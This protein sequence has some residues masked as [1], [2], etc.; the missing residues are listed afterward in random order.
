MRLTRWLLTG[1]L[2]VILSCSWTAWAIAASS[3]AIRAYDDVAVEGKDFH[4]QRLAMAEFANVKLIQANFQGA[5]LRGVVFNGSDLRQANFNGADLTDG[6]AY[7][8]DFAGADFTNANLTSAML[9]QSRFN[10]A[11]VTGA[12]FSLATLDKLQVI[13]LCETASGTNPT[14]GVDTRESLGCP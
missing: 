6:L 8:S 11:Q 12:D 13:A 1:L 4:G 5:D 9:L 3:A 10:D 7:L 14:T 2:T